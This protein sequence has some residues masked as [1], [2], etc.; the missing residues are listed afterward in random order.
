MQEA[1]RD[2]KC[3]ANTDII[4]TFNNKDKQTVT[5]KE[6]NTVN[7]FFPG[8]NQDNETRGSAEITQQLQRDFEDVFTGI[9]CFDGMF[10]LQIKPDSRPYQVSPKHVAYAL[11][12]PFKEELE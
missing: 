7:Y 4:S 9:G 2:K 8:P 10:S 5:G 1:D 11:E 3:Y 6:P 12:K